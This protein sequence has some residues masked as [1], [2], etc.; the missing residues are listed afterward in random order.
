[1]AKMYTKSSPFGETYLYNGEGKLVGRGRADS[2]GTTRFTGQ[3]GDY[4]GRCDPGLFGGSKLFG[5]DGSFMGTAAERFGMEDD[6]ISTFD[7]ADFD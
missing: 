6:D 4:I 3:R 5:S 2:S 7:C 1:M